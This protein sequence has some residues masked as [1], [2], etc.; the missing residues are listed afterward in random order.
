M[1]NDIIEFL[2]L[3]DEELI[4]TDLTVTDTTKY[5]WLEKSLSPMFCPNCNHRMHSKGCTLRTIRH[6]ILQN[7]YQLILKV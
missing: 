5:I 4:F 2:D 7:G 3:K 1:S 6:P